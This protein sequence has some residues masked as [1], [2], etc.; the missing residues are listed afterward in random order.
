M[1]MIILIVLVVLAVGGGSWG[2]RRYGAA[3]WSPLGI[4]LVALV[5]LY[6]TGHLRG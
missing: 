2:H 4:I 5:I 6:F 1:L 3:G